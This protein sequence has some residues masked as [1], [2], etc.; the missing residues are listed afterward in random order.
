MLW[1][2]P[3]FRWGLFAASL[4][5]LS[6]YALIAIVRA[7]D[8]VDGNY[9]LVLAGCVVFAVVPGVLAAWL[10]VPIANRERAAE[11]TRP[12]PS[13]EEALRRAKTFGVG[14]LL[15][16]ALPAF[17]LAL[18]AGLDAGVEPVH[19]VGPLVCIAVLLISATLLLRGL[20]TGATV[21][22]VASALAGIGG[23][24]GVLFGGAKA[25]L[26]LAFALLF[27]AAP[28]FWRVRRDLLRTR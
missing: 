18:F 17:G 24:V 6:M 4:S 2:D 8:E 11:R 10:L 19:A 26:L 27:V 16:A 1:N 3:R 28:R 7:P 14:T 5:A 20:A 12:A 9:G 13:R 22:A 23:F 21:G 25:S 15:V